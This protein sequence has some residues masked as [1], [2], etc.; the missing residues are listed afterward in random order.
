M[1]NLL[2]FKIFILIGRIIPGSIIHSSTK[3]KTTQTFIY[4]GSMKEIRV[5]LLIQ[6][7]V[8]CLPSDEACIVVGGMAEEISKPIAI[9]GL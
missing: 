9:Q 5:H 7:N 3:L 4:M 1:S 6:Q 2:K 8:D